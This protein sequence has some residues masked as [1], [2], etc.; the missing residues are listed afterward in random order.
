MTFEDWLNESKRSG[1]HLGP[2][3]EDVEDALRA[4]FEAGEKNITDAR[5]A[6]QRFGEILAGTTDIWRGYGLLLRR[7]RQASNKTLGE[8]AAQFGYTTPELSDIESGKAR[9]P[10]LKTVREMIEFLGEKNAPRP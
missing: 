5:D 8:V 10:G 4:A 9:P 2:P 6:G 1:L 7:F 3:Y